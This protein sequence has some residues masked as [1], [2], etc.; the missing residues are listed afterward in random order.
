MGELAQEL[1][2]TLGAATGLVDRLI[3]QNLV[4]READPKDRRVVRVRVTQRG[5]RA[6]L[7]RRREVRRRLARALQELSAEERARLVEGLTRLRKALGADP[8]RG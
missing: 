8:E 6:H 2:I 3:A 1:H 4:E 5:K 7:A